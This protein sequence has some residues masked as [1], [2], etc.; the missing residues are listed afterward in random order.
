MKI[1]INAPLIA[2]KSKTI[3]APISRVWKTL[4]DINNW[5]QWQ[6][7]ISYAKLHGKLAKGGVF[8]WKAMR[9]NINSEL[10]EVIKNKSIGWTGK[11][12][13]MNAIHVWKLEKQGN[14]TKVTTEESLSGWLP[15]I[16]KL[17]KSDFLEQSLTKTL[18]NLKNQTEKTK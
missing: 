11:S 18:S 14:K 9:M 8:T 4:S 5:P 17:F 12:L 3:N 6:K 10:Q 13:G 16:I 2:K 1:Y 7:D 15:I